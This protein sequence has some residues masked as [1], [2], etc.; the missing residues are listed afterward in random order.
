MKEPV[1]DRRHA[2]TKYNSNFGQMQWIIDYHLKCCIK[3]EKF[4]NNKE[5]TL[6]KWGCVF[7]L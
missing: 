3:G 4:K 7:R 6:K 5:V 2:G 1:L